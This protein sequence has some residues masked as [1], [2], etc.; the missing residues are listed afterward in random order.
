MSSTKAQRALV[1]GGSGFIGFHLVSALARRARHVTCLAR[2]P[3][4]TTRYEHLERWRLAELEKLGA[5]VVFG[6]VTRPESFGDVLNSAS[7]VYHLAGGLRTSRRAT[8]FGVNGRGT[9]CVVEACAQQAVPPVVVLI[10]S[11]A[12]AGPSSNDRSRVETDPAEPVSDYGRS[13]LAGE[14]AAR[15]Y[16]GRVPITVI[17]PPVVFGE[18][19]GQT[20]SLFQSVARWGVHVVPTWRAY[21]YS[22]IHVA[23]LAAAMVLAAERGARLKPAGEPGTAHGAGVYFVAAEQH[24]TYAELGRMIGH[25]LGRPRVRIA[26]IGPVLCWVS[27]TAVEAVTRLRRCQGFLNYDKLREIRAGAWTCSAR[28]AEEQLGFCV[29]APLDE[30]LRQTA[31]WYR[32]HGWL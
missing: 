28:A 22:L 30:R 14:L 32:A 8:L 29:D 25:S 6:D 31:E 4:G 17:R 19:D 2:K 12:A 24:P 13:K 5:R 10:S 26:H 11:L 27:A 20:L 15:Q 16:A 9:K 7:E 1:T 3:A 23:D 18:T 21:R